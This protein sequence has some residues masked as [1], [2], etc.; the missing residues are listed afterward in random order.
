MP[1]TANPLFDTADI[2]AGQT[3][4]VWFI[5]GTFHANPDPSNPS[6]SIGEADREGTIP[7]GTALFFPVMGAEGS[8]LEGNGTTK[9]ELGAAARYLMDHVVFME[10]SIDGVEVKNLWAYREESPLFF[11][12]PLPEDNMFEVAFGADAPAGST[13]PVVADGAYLFVNPLPPGVHKIHTGAAVVFTEA[14]DGFDFIL[15]SDIDYTITVKPG[16]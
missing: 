14:D 7:A 3:G 1:V 13:S 11:V 10:A 9:A 15:V 12:G 8:E 16:K 2:S 4:K 5:G 6:V